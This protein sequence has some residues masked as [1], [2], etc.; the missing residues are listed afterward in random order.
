M[1]LNVARGYRF[2]SANA[3]S[4]ST[5]EVA[6]WKYFTLVCFRAS[7]SVRSVPGA[8][9]NCVS[10]DTRH[11]T[12][13]KRLA[14]KGA[15]FFWAAGIF[16]GGSLAPHRVHISGDLR[17]DLKPFRNTG[18][19]LRVARQAETGQA[20]SL[21]GFFISCSNERRGQIRFRSFRSIYHS[22]CRP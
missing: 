11:S 9:P 13:L 16:T 22:A 19:G 17:G 8:A 18:A 15:A 20:P 14:P 2:G 5:K 7:H 10:S 3:Y 21:Q 6:S 4:C 12:S 1:G